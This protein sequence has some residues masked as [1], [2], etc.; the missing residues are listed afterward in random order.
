MKTKTPNK[1]RRGRP[2]AKV[3]LNRETVQAWLKT[4]EDAKIGI[5]LRAMLAIAE[6]IP[7]NMVCQVLDVSREAIRKWRRAV[8]QDGL[9]GLALKEGR[10]KKTGLTQDIRT[11]L[12][13]AVASAPRNAGYDVAVWTAKVVVQ[14]VQDRFG[15]AIA[16]RTAR[17]WLKTLG[18][19]LQRPRPKLLKADAEKRQAF[20]DE[21]KKKRKKAR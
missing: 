13:Q 18:F 3:S 16:E 19:T 9:E 17:T 2:A 21:L 8:Q 6:G 4:H 5:K 20:K 12:E 15:K 10:G 11:A 1:R 14:F 7:V